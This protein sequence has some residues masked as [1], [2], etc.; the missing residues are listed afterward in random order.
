MQENLDLGVTSVGITLG[1]TGTD[2]NVTGSPI[3][4]SGNITLNI[5]D[6][7][8]T[9]RGLVNTIPQT[10]NGSK[11][12]S[13]NLNVAGLTV[14]RGA[15]NGNQF[16]G[17]A[18]NTALGQQA[19]FSITTGFPNTA[20]GVEALRNITTGV[21]N[22]GIGSEAGKV[23]VI[24]GAANAT[25][26]SS[27]YI[28]NNSKP[29]ANGGSNEVVIGHNAAGSGSNTVTI[30]NSSTTL[31]R[32]FGRVMHGDAVAADQSATLGQVNTSLGGY[33]TLA[34]AQTI[35]AQKTF[36]TSGGSDT[37]IINHGSG[38]GI[39]LNITKAGNGEGLRVAKTSGSGNAMTVI[40][41]NFEAPTIVRTGGTSSQFLKADGSVDSST[42]L[43]T[44]TAASTYVPY[45]GATGGVDLGTH[46]LSANN[47]IANGG[48]NAGALL[49]K[50]ANAASTIHT[51]YFT[52]SP[53]STTTQISFGFSTGASTWKRLVFSSHLLTDNTPTLFSLPNGGGT[54]AVT[55]DLGAYLPLTGGTLT[56]AL[57][58]TSASF[59]GDVNLATS[60][61]NVG[62]FTTTPDIFGRFD[63][64]NLGVSVASASQ[65]LALQLNA[66]GSAGRGA[67]IYMG[68][69]GTRHFT[70]SS[71]ASE[72]R[73]GTTTNT[74]FVL[75]TNDTTR[76]TIAASTGAAT[77]SSSVTAGA[78][79][80]VLIVNQNAVSLS[81]QVYALDVDNL[82]QGSN[83]SAAGAF[84]IST[85]GN[86]G[87][88][89]INGLGN[90]SIG[91]L[92]PLGKVHA[93]LP[94]YTSEETNSQ[95]AIFG[96]SEGFGVRL[97]YD[98][99]GNT[100]YINS[101]KPGFNWS[102]LRVQGSN[103]I[104]APNSSERVRITTNGL[105][106]NGDTAAANA[107]DDYEEG[108]WTGTL[109][110]SVSDPST[111]VTATGN[112]TKIGRQVTVSIA[113]VAV[114]TTGAAGGVSVA[115]LPFS[116]AHINVGSVI[117]EFFDFTSGRT[118][119]ACY[120]N[121][122]GPTTILIESSG[123][124]TSFGGVLHTAGTG[125]YLYTTL[126]YFV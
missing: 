38:S 71:N 84:R 97:G 19:L 117:L 26:N 113:F 123:D 58:G 24:S 22:I 73:A 65:N 11:T 31:N 66:G 96:T 104:F 55:T 75:T 37:A 103:I 4:T 36:S 39:A 69:G 122:S 80:N 18:G 109:K 28:G 2:V 88:F 63:E 81:N 9:A 67:Q 94:R 79:G 47:V 68:Q 72:S 15:S 93:V 78:N 21:N 119:V 53:S 100:G 64:K 33:V 59:T 106:F 52:L 107:L 50:N 14:G 41:G 86:N 8:T 91:A 17:I 34:T 54:L 20:V 62:V 6:A 99:T 124:D 30:G 121:P 51:G 89:V 40:G 114:N 13:L 118:S 108:T 48:F 5:P 7:S 87:A 56:G 1:T 92:L 102:D 111:P 82:T 74:P 115:G 29:N 42:Y 85:N 32:F 44:G 116:A 95:Q 16:N 76:L 125:R 45:S 98:S 12:F 112:Y 105:T 57:N 10:F 83:M 110:G 126:T 101:I 120:T 46:T 49:L 60:S 70:L 23:D 27:I 25:S 61:G 90:V 3:T 77:F 35:T 43:T